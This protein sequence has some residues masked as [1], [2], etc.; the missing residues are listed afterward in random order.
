MYG[1]K[2]IYIFGLGWMVVWALIG[3]FSQNELMMDFSRAI[4]GFGPAAFLPAG[5]MLMGNSYRPGPRKNLVRILRE[6][7]EHVLMDAI[8][9]IRNPPMRNT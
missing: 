9:Q 8:A 3:G 6:L 7:S 2:I 1:G 5:V 4:A